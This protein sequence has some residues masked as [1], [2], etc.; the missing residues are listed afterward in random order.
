MNRIAYRNAGS[1]AWTRSL[2]FAGVFATGIAFAPFPVCSDVPRVPFSGIYGATA[3][4]GSLTGWD[5]HGGDNPAT[6]GAPG[7]GVSVAGYAP[8]GLDGLRV[9]ETSAAFDRARWGSALAWRALFEE[10]RLRAS[11]T[12]AQASLKVAEHLWGGGSLAIH[13]SDGTPGIGMGLGLLWRPWSIVSLAAAWERLG[14]LEPDLPDAHTRFGFGGDL[15]GRLGGARSGYA[16]R[17]AA[18]RFF[19]ADGDAETRFG[20]GFRFH[21]MLAVYAGLVPDRETA[22]LGVRF[23]TGGFE[24]FSALRRHSSLGGTSIQGIQW[25]GVGP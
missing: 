11:V 4:A 8:F 15:G 17:L 21:A 3:G 16:W 7:T 14:R 25:R 10:E 23:G 6:S 2:L 22:S 1:S 5:R 18:E 24:G 9:L 13:A 12:T 20:F 19:E